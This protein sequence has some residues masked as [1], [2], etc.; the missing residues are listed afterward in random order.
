MLPS[1]LSLNCVASS[2]GQTNKYGSDY[3]NFL[4]QVDAGVYSLH[5]IDDQIEQ[6]GDDISFIAELLTAG[7]R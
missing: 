2:T 6:L 7:R 3:L 4:R 1:K 5:N